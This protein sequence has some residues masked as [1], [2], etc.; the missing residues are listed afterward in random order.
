MSKNGKTP[1]NWYRQ[2]ILGMG[3]AV[4]GAEPAAGEKVAVEAKGELLLEDMGAKT[5]V[6]ATGTE[7]GTVSNEG[8][9][10]ITAFEV[11]SETL[12][13]AG[14]CKTPIKVV[15]VN[16]PYATQLV[17]VSGVELDQVRTGT[18]GGEPGWLVECE[19]YIGKQ[20]D[21]CLSN[22]GD[23]TVKNV[24]GGV[25]ALF[26]ETVEATCKGTL[27]SGKG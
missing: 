19:S 12:E 16:L 6:L 27:L 20:D 3:W 17:L 11:T 21:T 2:P 13:E 18:K 24:S 15:A 1:T 4:D 8:K 22:A 5:S 9:D 26:D 25:E 10:E 14:A 7:L 23:T